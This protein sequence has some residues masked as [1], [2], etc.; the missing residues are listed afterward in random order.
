MRGPLRLRAKP[1][2]WAAMSLADAWHE[3]I[4][5]TD[6]ASQDRGPEPLTQYQADPVGFCVEVLG[7][8]PETLTWSAN[9]YDGHR[10]DGSRDPLRQA[11]ECLSRYEWVAVSSGTGTGKTFVMAAALLWWI[12]TRREG[13]AVT[14]ATKEDQMVKGVWREV[15]RL[16]PAFQRRFPSAELTHLRIRMH[17][18]LA[19]AWAAWG[20]TAKPSATGESNT[21]VQGLHAAQLLILVDEMP[22]VD[23]SIITALEQ[24]ATDPGNVIA[25]FGNPDYDTDPLAK[26]GRQSGVTPIRISG[27]DHPNVVT[28]QTVV[29]GAVSRQSVAKRRADHGEDSRLFKSRVRGI[30]PEQAADA[31]IHR[32]WVEA[33]VARG[34]QWAADKSRAKHPWAVGADPANSDAGDEAAT[35]WFQ[36]AHCVEIE[37]APCPDANSYGVQV[38]LK[39]QTRGIADGQLLGVDGIGVGAGTVNRLREMGVA[40]AA[41]NSG[42]KPSSRVTKGEDGKGVAYD[43]NQFLNLRAQMYWQAREDLQYGRV[44]VPDDPQLIE[45]LVTPTYEVRNGKVVIEPKDDVKRRLGRSPNKADAFVYGNWVRPRTVPATPLPADAEARDWGLRKDPY[46]GRVEPTRLTD[47]LRPPPAHDPERF[48]KDW[49][50]GR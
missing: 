14:V 45:E 28:G 8:R 24:T 21:S 7:V 46:T 11:L 19:D 34:R 38:W 30:A 22:G 27:L 31:L 48:W 47:V 9:G 25:G 23:P 1:A 18:D 44:G 35:A 10:W 36:G 39:A 6:P 16:F 2:P 5:E 3:A 17:P 32:Q 15:G 37:S 41:L 50:R 29:P 13:I 33:A 26:F 43:A 20:I 12:G 40:V 49:G 4:A 42:G